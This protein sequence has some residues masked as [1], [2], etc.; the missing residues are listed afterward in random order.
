MDN[1]ET[2]LEG[3]QL[4]KTGPVIA[5]PPG[6]FSA[7][8]G[9]KAHSSTKKGWAIAPAER[10]AASA[11]DAGVAAA[12]KHGRARA[13]NYGVLVIRYADQQNGRS[14]LAVGYVGE[15]GI[16]PDTWYRVD[17]EGNFVEERMLDER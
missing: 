10:G 12:G 2:N 8:G 4:W 7:G 14:R 1:R 17:D 11:A 16:K 13:G 6:K 5:R 15:N 9:N 3:I